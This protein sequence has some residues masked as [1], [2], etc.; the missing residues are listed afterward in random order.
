MC[1]RVYIYQFPTEITRDLKWFTI[2][3]TASNHILFVILD[4][5]AGSLSDDLR[6]IIPSNV[7]KTKHVFSF[8]SLNGEFV[9]IEADIK[10]GSWNRFCLLVNKNRP[11]FS[12]YF[13]DKIAYQADTYPR[14]LDEG[15]LWVLGMEK[16]GEGEMLDLACDL[17]KYSFRSRLARNNVDLRC[18]D[19]PPD[20]GWDSDS[21]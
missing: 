15:N 16:A 2:L 11:Y 12:L 20:L 7:R 4:H 18:P 1:A 19:R 5:D 10:P 21:L 3:S 17:I 9:M 14:E 13:N 6:Y 8:I